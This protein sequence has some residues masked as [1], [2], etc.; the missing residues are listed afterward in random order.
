VYCKGQMK[1]I[2]IFVVVFIIYFAVSCSTVYEVRDHYDINAN[3]ELLKT[4][5]WLPIQKNSDITIFDMKR[6]RNSVN[7]QLKNKG[8]K[9]TSDSPEFLIAVHVEK[10]EKLSFTN[11][12][13][14]Y[15][16]YGGYWGRRYWGDSSMKVYRYEE[17]NLILD[18]IDPKSKELIWRG[19][20]K[21]VVGNEK[22]PEERQKKIEKTVQKILEKYPPH[23][24]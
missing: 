5:D 8:L 15:G 3:F 1:T 6:I 14:G 11:P 12:G 22:T 24:Q 2:N 16:P 13:D 23:P 7:S 20:A 18:F 10:K 19:W 9:I 21:G 4:Y 17:G